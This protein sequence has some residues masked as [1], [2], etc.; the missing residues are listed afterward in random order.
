MD[1]T[2]KYA[3]IEAQLARIDEIFANASQE[4]LEDSWQGDSDLYQL[5]EERHYWL[6]LAI[7]KAL[8]EHE[9]G[10]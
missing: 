10:A 7:F 2:I 3:Y 5:Q 8:K 4:E 1:T 6:D 9:S